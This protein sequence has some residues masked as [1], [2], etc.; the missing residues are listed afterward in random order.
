M[1]D[2]PP[3]EPPTPQENPVEIHKLKPIHSWREFLTELGTIVL[4]ICIAIS[5]E[6]LVEGWHWSH[7]VKEAR[8]VIHSE[9]AANEATFFV[10]RLSYKACLDRQMREAEA[11]LADLEAGRKPGR[12]TTFHYGGNGPT[13]DSGWEA[14]RAAQTLTHFPPE[15]LAMMGRYYS[16]LTDFKG[17]IAREGETWTDLAVLRGPPAGLGPSDFMRMR[18]SLASIRRIAGLMDL[19]TIRMLKLGDALDIPRAPVDQRR[20]QLY[21][22]TNEDEYQQRIKDMETARR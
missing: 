15:E 5:L 3:A 11:I 17:W 22:H 4:G 16:W 19:N 9:I 12:F 8:Q 1:T 10:R 14:Q 13:S 21:C 2:T 18:N 6:Q 7:E 20:L